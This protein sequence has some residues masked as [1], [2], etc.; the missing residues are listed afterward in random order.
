MFSLSTTESKVS[1]STTALFLKLFCVCFIFND[2]LFLFIYT[3][4]S[5]PLC[6]SQNFICMTC[7]NKKKKTLHNDC[8]LYV[9]C[10]A[11]SFVADRDFIAWTLIFMSYS[12]ILCIWEYRECKYIALC[13]HRH[14]LTIFRPY[15]NEE[16]GSKSN[17][18][19]WRQHE[20]MEGWSQKKSLFLL[21]EEF[22]RAL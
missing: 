1:W 16:S 22:K 19:L 4:F 6:L 7:L 18:W 2:I 13:L 20:K 10:H 3:Y 17:H 5:L 14:S 9:C 8:Y 11:G 12:V 15:A 21:P